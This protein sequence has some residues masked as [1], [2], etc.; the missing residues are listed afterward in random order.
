MLLNVFQQDRLADRPFAM[1]ALD[2]LPVLEQHQ[3]REAV[4]LEGDTAS[5]RDTEHKVGQSRNS[6][7]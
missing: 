4:H 1:A 7:H 5:I 2:K 6:K 3:G